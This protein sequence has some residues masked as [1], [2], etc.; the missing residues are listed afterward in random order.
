MTG[1]DEIIR[2]DR[3]ASGVE[4]TVKDTRAAE[5]ADLRGRVRA[6]R[7][8]IAPTERLRASEAVAR[9]VLALP[10][11]GCVRSALVYG[12]SPEEI[13]PAPLADALASRGIRIAYPRVI[14]PRALALHWVE[15]RRRLLCGAFGL[16]EPEAAEPRAALGDLDVIIAPGVAFDSACN[17]LGYGGGYY[18]ALLA[19]APLSLPTVGIAFDVQIVEEIPRTAFDRPLDI[20]VTPTRVVRRD[21]RHG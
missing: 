13:D 5:K 7:R 4:G 6:A 20:V 18:D 12:A 10:E 15:D 14:G 17:R 8:A 1:P 9:S 11:L 16:R 19:E 2:R 3:A 21:R